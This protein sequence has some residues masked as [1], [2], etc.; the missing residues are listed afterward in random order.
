MKRVIEIIHYNEKKGAYKTIAVEVGEKDGAM[1][2]VREGI[3]GNKNDMKTIIVGLSVDELI[4]LSFKLRILAEE[5]VK[6]NMKE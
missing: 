1:L 4:S 2:V 3:K 6:K 5:L